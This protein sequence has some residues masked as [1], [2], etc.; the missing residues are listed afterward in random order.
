MILT[1]DNASQLR[2]I[3]QRGLVGC[4][5]ERVVEVGLASQ[6]LNTGKDS[7]VRWMWLLLDYRKPA[8]GTIGVHEHR[9]VAVDQRERTNGGALLSEMVLPD[10][11]A[12]IDGLGDR[13]AIFPILNGRP[14]DTEPVNSVLL[15]Q[16]QALPPCFEFCCVDLKSSET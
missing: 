15:G 2:Q 5:D 16:S 7:G 11:A 12:Y 1:T 10:F 4:D 8:P 3:S 6:L 13:G 14:A 9:C